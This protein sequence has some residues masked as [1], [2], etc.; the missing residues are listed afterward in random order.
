MFLIALM[1]MGLT[2]IF[3]ILKVVNFARGEFYTV[4]TY[5]YTLVALNLASTPGSLCR[6]RPAGGHAR[7]LAERL[8]MRPLYSGYASG[9]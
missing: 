9:A 5:A 3:G 4:G 7:H 1:A 6:S 2:F 8:L